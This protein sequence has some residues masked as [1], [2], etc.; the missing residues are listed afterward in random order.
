[1]KVSARVYHPE[2]MNREGAAVG[3]SSVEVAVDRD[4]K[5]GKL[6]TETITVDE[7]VA[8]ATD[9]LDAAR[10]AKKVNDRR[11]EN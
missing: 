2:G 11:R 7:A 5:S 6:D 8:L 9:L 4:L 3:P 10:I 1:M